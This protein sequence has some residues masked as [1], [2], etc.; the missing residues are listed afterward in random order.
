MRFENPYGGTSAPAPV[1][2]AA[3]S[4]RLPKDATLGQHLNIP[5]AAPATPSLPKSIGVT[6]IFQQAGGDPAKARALD[7]IYRAAGVSIVDD[8]QP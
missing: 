6:Q 4:L 5:P 3:A 1:V 8:R 2:P 7:K